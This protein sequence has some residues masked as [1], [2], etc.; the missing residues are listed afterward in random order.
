MPIR[1]AKTY[2]DRG[3]LKDVVNGDSYE[4]PTEEELRL[5]KLYEYSEAVGD[6]QL[7]DSLG[8]I[9]MSNPGDR[10]T[11]PITIYQ[12]R[13]YVNT[14]SKKMV[15]QIQKTRQELESCFNVDKPNM[16]GRMAMIKQELT[17]LAISPNG[18]I[19]KFASADVLPK[20]SFRKVR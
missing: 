14:L 1:S 12:H 16:Q 13:E 15:D 7:K 9:V 5:G 11:F 18:P 17:K 10:S 2:S 4:P 8:F 20:R 6:Q 3:S 19:H